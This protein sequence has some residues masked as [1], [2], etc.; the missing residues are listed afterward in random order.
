MYNDKWK[1]DLISLVHHADDKMIKSSVYSKVIDKTAKSD[2]K[3]MR[4][5]L[6][7]AAEK[8]KTG[9]RFSA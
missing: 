9:C 3:K 8:L 5:D 7:D 1:M 4:K 2:I 6:D